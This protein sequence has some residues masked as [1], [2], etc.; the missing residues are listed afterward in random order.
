MRGRPGRQ[1]DADDEGDLVQ[2]GRA[3]RSAV[4]AVCGWTHEHLGHIE[5]ARERYGDR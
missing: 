3:L 5:R 1:P 2:R 4:D